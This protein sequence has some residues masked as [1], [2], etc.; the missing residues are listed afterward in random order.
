M[1][2]S[3]YRQ[4]Y[5]AS[6]SFLGILAESRCAGS[7]FCVV[8]LHLDFW[9]SRSIC[10]VQESFLVHAV[11]YPTVWPRA[12]GGRGEEECQELS[13]FSNAKYP[14]RPN[15]IAKMALAQTAHLDYDG[16]SDV[17]PRQRHLSQLECRMAIRRMREML[18]LHLLSSAHSRR[19]A[20][21]LNHL[22]RCPRTSIHHC[23]EL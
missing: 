9:T 1:R 2:G 23:D 11:S 7:G 20:V 6:S 8:M 12:F 19:L 18:M 15:R 10:P 16:E 13:T 3:V 5:Q 22:H 14:S 4:T 21:C 17:E